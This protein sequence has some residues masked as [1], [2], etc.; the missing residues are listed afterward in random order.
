MTYCLSDIHGEYDLFL[1]LLERIG[2]ADTDT[3]IVCGDIVD[4]GRAS[5]RLFQTIL[6]LPG[7]RCIMGNHEYLFQKLYRAETAEDDTDF[8]A[9][10]ARLQAYF[11]ED[12]HLLDWDTVD[13][14]T[15]LPFYYEAPDFL[16]VHA[17]LPLRADGRLGSPAKALPEELVYDRRFKEPTFLPDGERCVFFGHTP[18]TYIQSKPRILRY[19]RPHA[20]RGSR[21]IRDY[22]KVHLDTGA[23][24]SGVLG[25]FCVEDCTAA[26]VSR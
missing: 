12:G 11:P 26:Y 4:K 21:C 15:E 1:R 19:P 8:D 6:A 13:A 5:V 3:L 10:L 22:A 7:A 18:T 25:C 17:G 24:L 20:P 16:C 2:Y 9:V 23:Y 14:L